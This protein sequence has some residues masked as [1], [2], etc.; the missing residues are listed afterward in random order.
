MGGWRYA[1]N[2]PDLSLDSRNIVGFVPRNFTIKRVDDGEIRGNIRLEVT[3]GDPHFNTVI[4]LHDSQPFGLDHYDWY[5]DGSQEPLSQD[6]VLT[7]LNDR[8]VESGFVKLREELRSSS[9]SSLPLQSNCFKFGTR[10]RSN[11][12]NRL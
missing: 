6:K 1:G 12:F 8:T 5:V 2:Y 11:P 3:I 9:F 7:K 10:L 4:R